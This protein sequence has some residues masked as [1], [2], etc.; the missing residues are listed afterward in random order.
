MSFEY[1][2]FVS[3][4]HG[5]RDVMVPLIENFVDGLEREILLQTTKEVFYDGKLDSGERLEVLGP[6]L[7]RSVCMI[8]FYTPLYFDENHL[9]C[10][11]ELKAMHDLEERRLKRLGNKGQGLIIPII[12]RGPDSF[13]R[14]LKKDR[15]YTDFTTI[16]LN[17][18]N[19]SIRT[20][21]AGKIREIAEYIIKRCK[22]FE[23]LSPQFIDDCDKFRLPSEE[24][25]RHFV[26][27]VLEKKIVENQV[28]FLNRTKKTE[29]N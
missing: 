3:Y 9:Y 27:G 10:A 19:Y 2:C 1:S 13:P 4:P 12:L 6:I 21:F 8:L 22:Q 18:R 5:Q 16:D 7:C 23:N 17:N 28:P 11:R 15:L 14:A 24:D 20:K 25:A 26:E 29:R